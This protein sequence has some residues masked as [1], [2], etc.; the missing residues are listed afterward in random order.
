M[1]YGFD[2]FD[3]NEWGDKPGCSAFETALEMRQRGAL[4]PA[5]VPVLDAH[6]AACDVCRDHAARLR[7]IDASLAATAAPPDAR[8]AR[9]QLDDELKATRRTPWLLAGVGLAM[10]VLIAAW[11]RRF[12]VPIAQQKWL[13]LFAP[14]LFALGGLGSRVRAVRLGR[15]LAEPDFVGAHRRW[16]EWN[17]KGTR[18]L[19][20]L[21]LVNGVFAGLQLSGYAQRYDAGDA[22]AGA[23]VVLSAVGL[24]G[25]VFVSIHSW[26]RARRLAAELAEMH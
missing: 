4:A 23:Y 11:L 19:R 25:F 24:L 14:L 16:V 26:R 13:L 22:S 20:W 9:E 18:R 12:G 6:L 17:L 7:R 15:L 10:A 2:P 21:M 5:A 1:R 3:P 8:R